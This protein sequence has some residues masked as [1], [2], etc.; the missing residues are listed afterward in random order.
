VFTLDTPGFSGVVV[1]QS[2]TLCG[3]VFTLDIP[4][5]FTVV[6]VAQYFA[7][8]VVLCLLFLEFLLFFCWPLYSPFF[9]DL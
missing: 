8:Y 7:F 4:V 3:V 1:A 5:F 6:R 9:Y 2:F